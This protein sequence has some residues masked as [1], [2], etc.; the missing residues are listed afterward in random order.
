MRSASSSGLRAIRVGG[1]LVARRGCRRLA[2]FA[3]G[4]FRAGRTCRQSGFVARPARGPGHQFGLGR[5]HA[6]GIHG[7]VQIQEDGIHR[8]GRA[9]RSEHFLHRLAARRFSDG[10]PAI[11]VRPNARHNFKSTFLPCRETEPAA[12]GIG[13]AASRHWVKCVGLVGK[14]GEEH[15][16]AGSRG[17]DHAGQTGRYAHGRGREG[18]EL[19]A[20]HSAFMSRACVRCQDQARAK[21][22]LD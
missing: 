18:E 3:T 20:G 14:T 17:S 13:V 9:E 19:T 7:T 5:P 16:A 15:A 21:A 10:S 12:I 11:G 1:G 2:P 22:G 6:F 8:Q 4:C